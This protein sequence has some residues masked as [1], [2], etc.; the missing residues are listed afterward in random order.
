[1]E[2]MSKLASFVSSASLL[3]AS[4]LELGATIGVEVSCGAASE[5]IVSSVDT[6]V[7]E[8]CADLE[9]STTA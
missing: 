5:L 2:S 1:M 3:A 7:A 8:F 6:G 9:D 4:V